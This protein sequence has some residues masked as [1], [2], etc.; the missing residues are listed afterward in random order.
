[1]LRSRWTICLVVA[2]VTACDSPRPSPS[3]SAVAPLATQVA[4]IETDPL[5]TASADPEPIASPIEPT[6]ADLITA[7]VLAG[8][9]DEPTGYLYRFYATWGD[10]RL[11]EAYWA[12]TGEDLALATTI[13][14]VYARASAEQREV[15]RPFVVRPSHPDSYWNADA[16]A[17][18]SIG[19]STPPPS[20]ATGSSPP[21]AARGLRLARAV[22]LA[23]D[24]RCT[25]GRWAQ[26]ELVNIPVTIWAHCRVDAAGSTSL[27][28]EAAVNR[29]QRLLN[30]IW[31]PMVGNMGPPI[32]DRFAGATQHRD[33]AAEVGD[34]RLDIYLTEAPNVPYS[35]SRGL[36]S[37]HSGAFQGSSSP[38]DPATGGSAGY[39]VM[40]VARRPEAMDQEATMAH[41]LFHVLQSAHNSNGTV[42][43]PYPST[44][45]DCQASQRTHHWFTEASAQWAVHE[46]LPTHRGYVYRS[47]RTFLPSLHAL[48]STADE[49]EYWSFMW[50]LFMEQETLRGAGIVGDAWSAIEGKQGWLAVQAALDGQLGFETS[51]RDF[52]VRVWNQDLQP[53]DPI[54]PRFQHP[55]LDAAFPTTRPDEAAVAVPGVPPPILRY[56]EELELRLDVLDR[57]TIRIPELWAAYYRLILPPD[58]RRLTLNF[59]GLLP[60]DKVDVDALVRIR[61]VGWERRKLDRILTEWCLDKP[62]EAVEDVILV[63]SNHSQTPAEHVRGDWTAIATP[64]GCGTATDSLVFTSR[65][66]M[67]SPGDPYYSTL[68]ETLSVQLKLKRS[69][70]GNGYVDDGSTHTASVDTTAFLAGVTGGDCHLDGRGHGGSDGL[71]RNAGGGVSAG[72]SREFIDPPPGSTADP[73]AGLYRMSVAASVTVTLNT[74]ETSCIG[75]GTSQTSHTV[76]FPFCEGIE[77]VGTGGGRLFDFDCV[78]EGDGL[79]WSL[80]GMVRVNT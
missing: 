69:P 11:P 58:A 55:N 47:F 25:H 53:G 16:D 38:E 15:L 3:P 41:E 63:L 1:M 75:T 54:A 39:I 46:F 74:S 45:S 50:P 17:L 34:G 20:D 77:I 30:R 62:E 49:N 44:R 36:D 70:D 71:V 73:V 66:T 6:A 48:S 40:D 22:V 19:P 51:F 8:E 24:P 64:G 12:P 43:C 14:D 52:A 10:P 67:G 21:S 28:I 76:Q 2:L 78:Y 35:P 7:A 29:V 31:D 79:D 80:I 23:N 27:G 9:I 42:V 5:P 57:E 59:S 65:Y 32:P 60:S 72:I 13:D 4:A 37:S 68:R 61:D 56:K 18:P 26:R 33:E